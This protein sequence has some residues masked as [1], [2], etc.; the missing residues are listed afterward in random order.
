MNSFPFDL[1]LGS[2]SPRRKDLL[3]SIKLSFEVRKSDADETI[4][5][6]L[7][8]ENAALYLA[9]VKSKAFGLLND[10]TVLLTA[11]TIVCLGQD[12][13]NKPKDHAEAFNMLSS[14]SGKTHHVITAVCL[15]SSQR[16][17]AF[18]VSTAVSFKSLLPEEINYYIEQYQ[19]Y[20][21]AGSYGIQEWIGLIGIERIEGSY[22]NV[23]G[24]PV[25]EVYEALLTF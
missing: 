22:F 24:L 2:G 12:I 21:K 6:H 7:H 16:S 25:K 17:H 13:L 11:D 3:S 20:D 4:P 14:L 5:D 19:P 15:R 23:V 8:G 1:I 10:K 9:E 18:H